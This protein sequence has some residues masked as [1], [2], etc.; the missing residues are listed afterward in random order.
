MTKKAPVMSFSRTL[1]SALAT[2]AT[3]ALA[4]PPA[5]AGLTSTNTS[6][7]GPTEQMLTHFTSTCYDKIM[8]VGAV[9]GDAEIK[10][11][12][13]VTG[14]ALAAFKPQT[15]PKVLK[16]WRLREGRNTFALTYAVSDVDGELG[17]KLPDFA[18]GEAHSCSIISQNMDHQATTSAL[19]KLIGRA[20]DTEVDFGP[21][22]ARMW[23]GVSKDFAVFLYHYRSTSG[24]RN[25]LVNI[26]AIPKP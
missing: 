11:W 19:K 5:A 20:Y 10:G 9:E 23:V 18:K 3:L 24:G 13:A 12:T 15:E 26:T 22:K 1:L 4:S 14:P 16:A 21:L 6:V 7:S 2:V 8:N 17:A 25:G